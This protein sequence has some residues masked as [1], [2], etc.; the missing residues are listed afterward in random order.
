VGNE[1]EDA[2]GFANRIPSIAVWM[3]VVPRQRQGID[4]RYLTNTSAAADV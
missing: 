4:K 3:R 2:V 1:Q